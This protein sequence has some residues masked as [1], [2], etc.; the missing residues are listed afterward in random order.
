MIDKSIVMTLSSKSFLR[1]LNVN[2]LRSILKDYVHGELG[3]LFA[4]LSGFVMA[5]EKALHHMI[6]VH[7]MKEGERFAQSQLERAFAHQ[8][9]K[10]VLKNTKDFEQVSCVQKVNI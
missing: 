3:S 1:L 10:E 9:N 2:G 8:L 7:K 6:D 4:L 5:H